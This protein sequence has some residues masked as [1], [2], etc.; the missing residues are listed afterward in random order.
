MNDRIPG[1]LT[2]AW[3]LR[4]DS[5]IMQIMEVATS[6][7]LASVLDANEASEG[8]RF[9][10]IAVNNYLFQMHKKAHL[11][12]KQFLILFIITYKTIKVY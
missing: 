4:G 7:T 1:W 12:T 11:T 5:D 9:I 10:L 6:D 8:R 2:I 3:W